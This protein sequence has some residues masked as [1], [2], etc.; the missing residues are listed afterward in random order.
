[1]A[2]N[3]FKTNAY[4][5]T[6]TRTIAVSVVGKII[7]SGKDKALDPRRQRKQRKWM[8]LS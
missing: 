2:Y 1:M 7:R 3:P 5:E 8:D 6:R 4:Y